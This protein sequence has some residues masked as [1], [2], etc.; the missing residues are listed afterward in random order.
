VVEGRLVG[1]TDAELNHITDLSMVRKTYKLGSNHAN[2]VKGRRTVEENG[3]KV[4]TAHELEVSIL[5]M[6]ALKGAT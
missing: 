6:M 5:G 2:L 1:F 3:L 4:D